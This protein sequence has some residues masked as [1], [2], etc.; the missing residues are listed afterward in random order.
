M[1]V[2]NEAIICSVRINWR[3]IQ[4]CVAVVLENLSLSL[5][6]WKKNCSI[7]MVDG[8]NLLKCS[9]ATPSIEMYLQP[10]KYC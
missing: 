10:D 2:N 3:I 6:K 7:G 8:F 4:R 1:V 5:D 9:S